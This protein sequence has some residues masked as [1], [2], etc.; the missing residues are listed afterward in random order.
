MADNKDTRRAVV[1]TGRSSD[2]GEG[3][4]Y[5]VQSLLDPH[6]PNTPLILDLFG[7][8]MRTLRPTGVNSFVPDH[9]V[10]RKPRI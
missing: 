2:G 5:Q 9:I 8:Q 7:Y 4:K 10:G 1:M 6:P 3:S